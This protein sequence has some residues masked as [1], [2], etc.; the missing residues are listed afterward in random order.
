MGEI[1]K[2]LENWK[3]LAY[4]N[5]VFE[6][7][8]SIENDSVNMTI[9][10]TVEKGFLFKTLTAKCHMDKQEIESAIDKL[11]EKKDDLI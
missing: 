7:D 5:D 11:D 10:V 8:Y 4:S 3:N 1:I 6:K 9:S 2:M